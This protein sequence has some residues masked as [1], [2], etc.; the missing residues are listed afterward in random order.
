M[1]NELKEYLIDDLIN[2]IYDF[3][4]D[5][6]KW[7]EKIN[8]INREHYFFYKHQTYNKH[9][10]KYDFHISYYWDK[11]FTHLIENKNNNHHV[12]IPYIRNKKF[13]LYLYYYYNDN[14]NRMLNN[15][16]N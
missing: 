11:T 14:I 16:T 9:F 12:I 13:K 6:N 5:F 1:I 8:L 4:K 3:N 2:I 7:K 15:N 10:K